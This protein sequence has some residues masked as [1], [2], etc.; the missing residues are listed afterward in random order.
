MGFEN[1][2]NHVDEGCQENR[3]RKEGE[4]DYVQMDQDEFPV[5]D[6]VVVSEESP[7]DCNVTMSG[8]SLEHNG[9]ISEK[10]ASETTTD[11][12]TSTPDN[13]FNPYDQSLIHSPRGVKNITGQ[14][15][16]FLS[17]VQC[18]GSLR[19]FALDTICSKKNSSGTL[20]LAL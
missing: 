17:V 6:L 2:N 9:T 13:M 10:A 3:T 20:R 4:A 19:V 12:T 7:E 16:Y 15:C 18:L 14:L 5:L 11:A 8:E 1:E